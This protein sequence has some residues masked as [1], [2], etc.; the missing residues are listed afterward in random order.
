MYSGAACGQFHFPGHAQRAAD[1]LPGK[2]PIRDAARQRNPQHFHR[3]RT[4]SVSLR[5]N[6]P[7]VCAQPAGKQSL[8][9]RR[10]GSRSARPGL[11]DTAST[12][13]REAPGPGRVRSRKEADRG[14]SPPLWSG[15]RARRLPGGSR[16]YRL[17]SR[18]CRPGTSP[19]RSSATQVIA[20]SIPAA[21]ACRSR[22]GRSGRAESDRAPPCMRWRGPARPRRTGWSVAWP[23]RRRA[24]PAG[25][26]YP[27]E[28]PVS[29]F[30]PRSRGRPRWC[31]FP[32]ARH[33]Y[34]IRWRRARA[35]G[36]TFRVFPPSAK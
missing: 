19:V 28:G 15:R 25:A 29:R 12:P 3:A 5:T 17:R 22:Q 36:Q 18:R 11:P 24:P 14:C 34:C 2:G 4:G 21:A 23:G 30:L 7:H 6:H 13:D 16:A 8:V 32:A 1:A 33:F 26:R 35:R 10:A 27:R 20:A 31:P 9:P